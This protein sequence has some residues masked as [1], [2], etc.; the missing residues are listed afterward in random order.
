[1]HTCW[2]SAPVNN[3]K[4]VGPSSTRA[5]AVL[6]GGEEG[7]I[8][9][10][11][12]PARVAWNLAGAGAQQAQCQR[13]LSVRPRH[14]HQGK[15]HDRLAHAAAPSRALATRRVPLGRQQ[16]EGVEA[17]IA[18]CWFVSRGVSSRVDPECAK[19][20]EFAARAGTNK[21]CMETCWPP[22]TAFRRA[23]LCA[24]QGCVMQT[25]SRWGR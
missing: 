11:N 16:P 4:R 3:C 20:H 1:M 25:Q 6:Q 12:D 8:G 2:A 9:H 17:N 22:P 7:E 10:R 5:R 19:H 23:F 15:N 21:H 13:S 14:G 24:E 18:R